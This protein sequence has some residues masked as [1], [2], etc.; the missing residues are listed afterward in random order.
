M[1]V[2]FLFLLLLRLGASVGVEVGSGPTL[3]L[4]GGMVV[5]KALV[6]RIG[7]DVETILV[8]M[9]VEA[10]IRRSIG[11]AQQSNKVGQEAR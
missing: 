3:F 9:R 7:D 1:V 4:L 6:C 2:D 8:S 5:N 10:I 11:C